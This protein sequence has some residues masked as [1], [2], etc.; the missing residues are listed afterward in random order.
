MK[1][2]VKS[3]ILRFGISL[4]AMGLI[5][6]AMRGSLGETVNILKTEVIWGWFAVGFLFYFSANLIL[7]VRLKTVLAVQEIRLTYKQTLHLVFTGLFFNLFLPSAVGGDIAKGYYA[8]QYSG[9]KI[10]S[11][12]SV[13][14]DRLMGFVAMISTALLAVL[15]FSSEINDPRVNTTIYIFVGIML[16]IVVFLANKSLASKFVFLGKLIPSEKIKNKIGEL[17]NSFNAYKH[18]PGPLFFMILL[19]FAGQVFFITM[20]Y[21]AAKSLSVEIPLVT[22][23]I[24]VPVISIVA[25][26]PSLGGLGVREAGSVYL[27]S[28]FMPSERALA[29][30]L[31]INMI[32]YGLCF[33]SGII[34][35]LKGGLK[36]SLMN[37]MEGKMS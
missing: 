35:S 4:A 32:V 25:M 8:Y 20:H 1:S 34:Y 13:I 17:Y 29:L 5:I 14:I 2:G 11:T 31:L 23:F 36:P 24:I 33:I 12:T 22:Y 7:T 18:H 3:F 9:K 27:F 19:S 10:E 6:Y 15:I 16:V 28:Q 37:E 30:S 26:A 21:W